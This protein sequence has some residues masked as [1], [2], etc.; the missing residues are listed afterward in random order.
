MFEVVQQCDCHFAS[1]LNV[2]CGELSLD[3]LQGKRPRIGCASRRNVSISIV[4][5]HSPNDR[6]LALSQQPNQVSKKFALTVCPILRH[7]DPY[8]KVLSIR[9]SSLAA[10]L[11]GALRKPL[12]SPLPVFLKACRMVSMLRSPVP[13]LGD[14]SCIDGETLVGGEVPCAAEDTGDLIG[15]GDLG[16][17]ILGWL[18]IAA[19]SR[20]PSA[21][22]CSAWTTSAKE[23]KLNLR[24][25]AESR[26]A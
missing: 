20:R 25:S 23:M 4:M 19:E 1:S 22:S 18:V 3:N 21:R 14:A 10:G 13:R 15:E 8:L 24:T 2:G 9:P 16:A 7:S 5:L 11:I 26:L 6:R 12:R 17:P